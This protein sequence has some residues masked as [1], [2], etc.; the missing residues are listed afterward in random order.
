MSGIPLLSFV[1]WLPI[2][3]LAVLGFTRALAGEWLRLPWI[4]HLDE[5]VP[6]PPVILRP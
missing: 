1:V 6:D 5:R 3:G 4:G 2:L